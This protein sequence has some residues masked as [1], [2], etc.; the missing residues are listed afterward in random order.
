[1]RPKN[2]A[3]FPSAIFYQ[4]KLGAVFCVRTEVVAPRYNLTIS[5]RMGSGRL[6][7]V[8]FCLQWSITRQCLS[9]APLGR[10]FATRFALGSGHN[11]W[12][13]IKHD[14][15]KKDAL[16]SKARSLLSQDIYNAS[17]CQLLLLRRSRISLTYLSWRGRS[18]SE[19]TPSNS[20]CK[21]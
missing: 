20:Y 12:S 5:L 6:W 10:S 1:M 21:C 8:S 14:K 4:G 15:G 11:R 19:P 18:Q 9:R 17:K 2:S 3:E 16:K 13:K 7:R